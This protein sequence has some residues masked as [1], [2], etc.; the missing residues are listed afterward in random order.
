MVEDALKIAGALQENLAS[1]VELIQNHTAVD[2]RL[3][4]QK[5]RQVLVYRNSPVVSRYCD[6]ASKNPRFTNH[7]GDCEVD[8]K[9][10][11]WQLADGTICNFDNVPDPNPVKYSVTK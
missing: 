1:R 6:P 9:L 7:S 4:D 11:Y 5:V 10:C 8:Y 2:A 3:N